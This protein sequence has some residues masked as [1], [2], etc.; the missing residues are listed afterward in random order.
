MPVDRISELL[1]NY[2]RVPLEPE[3]EPGSVSL[4]YV[5]TDA[6]EPEVVQL[7]PDP[8]FAARI[9][10]LDAARRPDLPVEPA[11]PGGLHLLAGTVDLPR[12]WLDA[13]V[14]AG[15]LAVNPGVSGGNFADDS[16]GAVPVPVQGAGSLVPANMAHKVSAAY[17][18]VE[19]PPPAPATD[20]TD[21]NDTA[22]AQNV[23]PDLP[24]LTDAAVEQ[25]VTSGGN[26]QVN[27]VVIDVPGSVGNGAGGNVVV[28]GLD[29]FDALVN[30]LTGQE[31]LQGFSVDSHLGG[32]VSQTIVRQFNNLVDQDVNRQSANL[33]MTE[34]VPDSVG[35][36]TQ[37]TTSGGN[38]L[39]NEALLV[40]GSDGYDLIIVSGNY[41]EYNI[42]VQINLIIDRD[43]NHAYTHA[44]IGEGEASQQVVASGGNVQINDAAIIDTNSGGGVQVIGGLYSEHFIAI[45]SSILF[46]GDMNALL[47]LLGPEGITAAAAGQLAASGGN[48]QINMALFGFEEEGGDSCGDAADWLDFLANPFAGGAYATQLVDA[49]GRPINVLFVDGDYYDVNFIMQVNIIDDSDSNTLDAEATGAH[50]LSGDGFGAFDFDQFSESGS[51]TTVNTAYI[52]DD[53][54]GF[55]AQ[56]VAGNYTEF[57]I[58]VQQNVLLDGDT[59]VVTQIAGAVDQF[60][61]D[62]LAEAL[63]QSPAAASGDALH[64]LTG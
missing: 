28:Q 24:D 17:A 53:N 47:A 49:D 48:I 7:G 32:A 14:G 41:Y 30:G 9:G 11:F 55:G 58:I 42:I 25:T 60:A 43:V 27:E 15:S 59:N 51:N 52:I 44:E 29:S 18:P 12:T 46:D 19:Q 64:T 36:V 35:T 26:I 21:T 3:G 56:V 33:A 4:A 38:S 54:G 6:E 5:R 62:E 50:N 16:I 40:S 61:R 8:V 39:S 13:H 57:N 37:E 23:R 2:L 22:D 63:A 20:T 31:L 1:W 10:E 45:Q 34:A